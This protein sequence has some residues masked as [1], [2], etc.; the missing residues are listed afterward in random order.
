M[1]DI[2]KDS[3]KML[4]G[5]AELSLATLISKKEQDFQVVLKS[6]KYKDPGCLIL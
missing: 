2:D 1:D 4:I 5:Q 3:K 6:E